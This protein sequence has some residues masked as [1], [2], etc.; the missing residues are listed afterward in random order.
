MT[1]QAAPKRSRW[2]LVIVFLSVVVLIVTFIV[3]VQYSSTSDTDSDLEPTSVDTLDVSIEITDFKYH[4]A[5]ISVPRGAR[6]TWY[7]NDRAPHTATERSSEWDTGVLDQDEGKTV[8]FDRP[9]AYEYYCT[10]HPY[11]SA[12]I[13]VR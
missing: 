6:V 5:D 13:T 1:E 7:N 8:T 12:R 9:G 2:P 3:G 11:M 4:P 10:I